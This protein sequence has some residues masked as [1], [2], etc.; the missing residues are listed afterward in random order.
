MN[1]KVLA[2]IPSRYD[3]SRFPGKPLASINGKSMIQRV[4]E[5]ATSC[6]GLHEVIVATDDQRIFDH[7]VSF[8]GKVAMTSTNHQSGTDRCGEVLS[9][10]KHEV[11]V[12]VNIQGDE[13]FIHP[14]QISQLIAVFEDSMV[15]I[16]TL[17]KKINDDNQINNPNIVKVVRQ[18]NSFALYFSR[19]PIPFARNT[20]QGNWTKNQDYYKHIGIYAYKAKVLEALIQLPPS[21]LETTESLEQLR[22]LENGYKI[23]VGTTD[24]ESIGIDTPEELQELNEKLKNNN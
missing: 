24:L 10:Y 6:P 3:S 15:D 13:P 17:A 8:G 2:I 16:S 20:A 1:L 11:D 21:K 7:V 23:H 9:N 14:K 18:S 19:S 22:W 12:V 4:Y 5:Q